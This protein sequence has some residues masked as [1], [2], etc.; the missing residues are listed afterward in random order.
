MTEDAFRHHHGLCDIRKDTYLSYLMA[1]FDRLRL[2]APVLFSLR[3]LAWTLTWLKF[4]KF[5][6]SDS[7]SVLELGEPLSLFSFPWL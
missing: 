3:N 4:Q 7:A 1:S 6:R 5:E 2:K